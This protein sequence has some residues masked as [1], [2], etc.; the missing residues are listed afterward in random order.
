MMTFRHRR[1]FPVSM[2]AVARPKPKPRYVRRRRPVRRP[3]FVPKPPAPKIRLDIGG[4]YI[5]WTGKND[6]DDA[7]LGAFSATVHY[8]K[9]ATSYIPP[10]RGGTGK[11]FELEPDL[12]TTSVSLGGGYIFGTDVVEFHPRLGLGLSYRAI[13]LSNA[14]FDDSEETSS[15][16]FCFNLGQRCEQCRTRKSAYSSHSTQSLA[17]LQ[18]KILAE[19]LKQMLGIYREDCPFGCKPKKRP[20]SVLIQANAARPPLRS[21]KAD[22]FRAYAINFCGVDESL[23]PG[24]HSS[25]SVIPVKRL[26]N[27]AV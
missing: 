7:G 22:Y 2:L 27:N 18:T 13:S 11:F 12:N 9:K 25:R 20:N 14:S 1:Y 17:V 8:G 26:R 16:L 5:S 23:T 6:F 4:A 3:K 15:S 21:T 24:S 10:Y 19:S